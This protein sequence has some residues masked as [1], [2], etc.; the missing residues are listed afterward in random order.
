MTSGSQRLASL[1]SDLMVGDLPDLPRREADLLGHATARHLASL[2]DA[3]RA[4]VRLAQSVVTLGAGVLGRRP[5]GRLEADARAHVVRR[6]A[7]SRV[8]LV[9][10]Y[11]RLV[12]GVALV[13]HFEDAR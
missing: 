11:F 4:G 5:Y 13:I 2:P 9:A 12:R 8:P 7:A 10:E 1:T 6:L 3:T